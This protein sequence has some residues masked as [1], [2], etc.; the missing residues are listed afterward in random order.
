MSIL[1]IFVASWFIV[2]VSGT[3]F[4]KRHQSPPLTTVAGITI[5]SGTTT[6]WFNDNLL[7]HIPSNLFVNLPNLGTIYFHRNVISSID[8]YAFLQV[9][10]VTY[11]SI[12]NNRLAIIR[13]HHFAGL[14]NLQT[15][16][17]F[18]NLIHT[19]EDNSFQD[20]T[21]L[22][23]LYLFDNSLQTLNQSVFDIVNHPSNLNV[24]MHSNPFQCE[25]L[26]WVKRAQQDG[27]IFVE[28]A[29]ST[30]CVGSGPF[31]GCTW[32][33]LTSQDLCP[34][35]CLSVCLCL[36]RLHYAPLQWYMGYLCT[37]K[38]QYAIPRRN[39]HHGAQGRLYFLKNLHCYNYF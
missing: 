24:R 12:R 36:L 21:A 31:N 22:S 29:P 5:P 6:V 39:M 3:S 18:S 30:G 8:D 1:Q 16:G 4:Y 13:E 35:I 25:G 37:R 27:W 9:P 38:A 10:S 2:L 15:L 28:A 7:T 26:C 20:N 33:Q 34:G 32:D 23:I 17:L 19:I 11:I 14:P